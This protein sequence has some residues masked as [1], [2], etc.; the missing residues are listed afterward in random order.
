MKSPLNQVLGLGTAREGVSHWWRQRV[1]AVALIPLGLWFALSLLAVDPGSYD[2]LIAWVRDPLTAVLLILAV[3]CLSYHS[4][5]GIA[6]VVEDYIG[7]KAAKI[8]V[9]LASSFAHAFVL[10]AS[11]FSILKIAFGAPA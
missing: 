8:V 11:L 2:E 1:T 7:G 3:T 10:A 5:L 4:W 6:V 9:L